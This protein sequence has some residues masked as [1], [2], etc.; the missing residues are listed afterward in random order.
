LIDTSERNS[1]NKTA[2]EAEEYYRELR[3]EAVHNYMKRTHQSIQGSPDKWIWEAIILLDSHHTLQDIEELA[4]YLERKYGWQPIIIGIHQDEGHIDEISG[5]KVYNLHAHVVF[6][7]LNKSGIFIFKKR[8]FGKKAM[9][10]LQDEV[11]QIL[12]MERGRS[13]KS[14]GKI[15]M[16][17]KQYRQ[18]AK[19]RDFL[20]IDL[21]QVTGERDELVEL[22]LHE[23]KLRLE[24]EQLLAK[25]NQNIEK[26]K[27]ENKRLKCENNDLRQDNIHDNELGCSIRL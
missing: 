23:Q 16:S 2:K 6:L 1:Y 25:K 27:T 19:E 24:Y 20:R 13:K 12:N 10:I 7:M 15:H 17:A 4:T 14:T 5:E 18:I 9:A 8:S 21:M 22:W 3:G 26:I 11:A